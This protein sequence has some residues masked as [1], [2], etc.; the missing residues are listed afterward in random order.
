MIDEVLRGEI[1]EGDLDRLIQRRDDG[2]NRAN[3]EA[4]LERAQA[5]SRNRRYR[6][7]LLWQKLD[8]HRQQ[9]EAHTRTFSRLVDRH[10]G[11]LRLV[12]AELGITTNEGEDAA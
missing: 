7:A 5:E 10:K 3:A 2:T 6:E 8:Y 4:A 11:A 1:V 12:E 9:L